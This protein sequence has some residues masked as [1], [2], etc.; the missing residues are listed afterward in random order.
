MARLLVEGRAA[1]SLADD[2][3]ARGNGAGATVLG[4]ARL[5]GARLQ[6][7]LLGG[8][9]LPEAVAGVLEPFRGRRRLGGARLTVDIDPVELP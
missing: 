6:V 8:A 4:P 2:L 3:A 7:V 9:E 1:A 5:A